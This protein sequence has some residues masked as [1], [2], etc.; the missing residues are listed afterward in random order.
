MS[1]VTHTER[2]EGGAA[3]TGEKVRYVRSPASQS[4][5]L[6]LLPA[7]ST[8]FYATEKLSVPS[9]G[10]PHPSFHDISAANI[11]LLLPYLPAMLLLPSP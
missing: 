6:K 3:I 9:V 1:I 5:Q 4:G 10:T 2:K 8:C 11:S 7:F